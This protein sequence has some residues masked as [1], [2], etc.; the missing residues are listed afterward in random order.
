MRIKNWSRFQ[1]FKDRKPPWIKLYRELLD[2][3]EWH[4]LDAQSSKVL[5]MLW[6][7]ASESDEG[8]LPE[9][10]EIAFRLRLSKTSI[11]TTISRLGH[12]LIHDDITAISCQYQN[13]SLETETETEKE[14]EKETETETD[15]CVENGKLTPEIL[16]GLFN[17]YPGI[18]PTRNLT[19][20]AKQTIQA[21][22]REYPELSWWIEFAKE[23]ILPSDFLCGKKNDFQASLLWICGPKN[24]DKIL[25]GQYVNHRRNGGVSHNDAIAKRVAEK[26]TK[27]EKR[28]PIIV[29][30]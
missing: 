16:V 5:V 10:E 13:D 26:L 12:W 2:D 29:N 8:I 20:T 11:K 25:A 3:L 18:K 19:G 17:A 22:I 24:M 14:T 7:L 15:L 23:F 6:L 28:E 4:K 9:I 1:H 27:G 30:Q 21:R